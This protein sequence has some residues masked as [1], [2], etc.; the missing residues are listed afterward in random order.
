MFQR[1]GYL[2]SIISVGLFAI[3]TWQG[4]ND[5]WLKAMVLL[6]IVTSVVGMVL[7]WISFERE[8]KPS[9]SAPDH[10]ARA[11]PA[12]PAPSPER[13]APGRSARPA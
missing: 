6:G 10:A 13:R 8:E 1:A 3:V 5:D 11:T 4:A 2:I 12:A 9:R 7:R